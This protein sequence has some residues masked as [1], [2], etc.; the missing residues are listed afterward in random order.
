MSNENDPAFAAPAEWHPLHEVQIGGSVGLT[1]LELF[2]AMALQGL[3]SNPDFKATFN[4]ASKTAMCH[5]YA[6]FQELKETI[7]E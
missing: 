3:L 4:G 2:A 5:A 1:K 6:L 7:N